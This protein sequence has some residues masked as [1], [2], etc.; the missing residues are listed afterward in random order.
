L[1]ARASR[2]TLPNS[3]SVWHDLENVIVPVHR[4]ILLE[5][6]AGSIIPG[7]LLYSENRNLGLGPCTEKWYN[8]RHGGVVKTQYKVQFRPVDADWQDAPGVYEEQAL[9]E[10]AA[11]ALLINSKVPSKEVYHPETR[12]VTVE[13]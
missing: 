10:R 9:A 11:N 5:N 2:D 4:E 8:R 6:E 7:H 13:G 12:V 1:Q 3:R